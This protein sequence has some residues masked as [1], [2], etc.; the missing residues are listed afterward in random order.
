[1]LGSCSDEPN[2]TPSALL[3]N[4]HIFLQAAVHGLMCISNESL[5]F[6]RCFTNRY[7]LFKTRHAPINIHFTVSVRSP[8]AVENHSPLVANGVT[9]RVYACTSQADKYV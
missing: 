9:V 7:L 1:M 8:L 3:P 2:Q 4:A 6:F 5:C